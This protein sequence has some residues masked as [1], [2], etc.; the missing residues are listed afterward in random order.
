M[1]LWGP[2]KSSS[3]KF[4]EK[5]ELSSSLSSTLKL[6]GQA[7]VLSAVHCESLIALCTYLVVHWVFDSAQ[8]TACSL[9][10]LGSHVFVPM[11]LAWRDA[12]S[13]YVFLS[14]K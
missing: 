11:T 9:Q 13:I 6:Q 5:V 4:N 12:Q 7:F 1:L 8:F 3:Q 10:Q 14:Y 2:G